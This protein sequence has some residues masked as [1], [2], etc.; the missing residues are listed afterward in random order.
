M[1]AGS[2]NRNRSNPLPWLA[3]GMGLGAALMYLIDPKKLRGIMQKSAT[4]QNTNENTVSDEVLEERVRNEFH[5]KIHHAKSIQIEVQDGVVTVSGPIL[6]DE[7]DRLISCIQKVPGVKRV[8]DHLQAHQTQQG[9]LTGDG[10][11]YLQ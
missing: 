11:T 2:S 8:E 4:A 1:R 3:L 10:K 6:V 9:F 5:R 7:V